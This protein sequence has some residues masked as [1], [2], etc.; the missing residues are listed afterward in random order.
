M[1]KPRLRKNPLRGQ[2]LIEYFI[3]FAIVVVASVAFVQR[4]PSI[5]TEYRNL[6]AQQMLQ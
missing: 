4:I 2:S 6:A 1:R 3:L 5:F